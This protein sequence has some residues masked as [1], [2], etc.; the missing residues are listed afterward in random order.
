MLG[1]DAAPVPA[2][3]RL[4][5]CCRESCQACFPLGPASPSKPCT[6]SQRSAGTVS[7]GDGGGSDEVADHRPKL[8]Q[9]LPEGRPAGT[10]CL[11][12]RQLSGAEDADSQT[13][14]QGCP[15][16]Q[17]SSQ[18]ATP[19]RRRSAAAA[20]ERTRQLWGAEGG[21]AVAATEMDGD[22]GEGAETGDE[23]ADTAD[24]GLE[25]LLRACEMLDPS[26]QL[27]EAARCGLAGCALHVWVGFVPFSSC[28]AGA[29]CAVQC[30]A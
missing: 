21:A 3:P 18:E 7:G 17:R 20:A 15:K 25:F 29:P 10:S 1:A 16:S 26:Q 28:G 27:F 2:P 9:L 13:S 8:Q 23:A 24:D 6:S 12:K 11:L 19:A 5:P 14:S 30:S 22:Y 4:R